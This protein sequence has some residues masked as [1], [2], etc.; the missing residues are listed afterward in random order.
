MVATRKPRFNSY[1]R[2]DYGADFKNP[3]VRET[4]VRRFS[5]LRKGSFFLMKTRRAIPQ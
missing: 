5:K 4:R 2:A 3:L 1:I